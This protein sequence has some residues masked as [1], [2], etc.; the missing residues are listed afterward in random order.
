MLTHVFALIIHHLHM[1]GRETDYDN[2]TEGSQDLRAGPDGY[3]SATTGGR[4]SLRSVRIAS[5]DMSVRMCEVVTIS[6]YCYLI[7]GR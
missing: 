7:S 3:S 6:L 5:I 1:L 4:R 2:A